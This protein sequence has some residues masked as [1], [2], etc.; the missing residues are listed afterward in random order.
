M[1]RFSFLVVLFLLGGAPITQAQTDM[2]TYVPP[3]PETWQYVSDQVMGG[4]SDGRAQV[5]GTG[6]SSHLT[7]SGDVS[8]RNRGGFI[9]TRVDLPSPLPTQAQGLVIRVRGNGEPYFVHLKTR[10]T[11]LPWQYYQAGFETSGDWAEIR[12]P[13]TAFKPSGRLLRR[14]PIAGQVTGVGFVAF[15]RDHR[16]DLSARWIGVY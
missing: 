10:G 13:F 3:P 9:Q 5:S 11:R 6:T 4:I 7:L 12:I 1:P 15:G 16:A 8:T 14:A 2:Q